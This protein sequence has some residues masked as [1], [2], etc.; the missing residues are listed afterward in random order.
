[1]VVFTKIA[2][3]KGVTSIVA[4]D[5]NQVVIGGGDGSLALFYVE[6]PDCQELMRVNL[7]GAVFSISPSL[8]SVQML[9]STNK[10]FIYRIRCADLS[11]ILLNENHTDNIISFYSSNDSTCRIGSCSLDGTIRLWSLTDFNV[12]SRFFLSHTL[13]PWSLHF[14]DEVM[15]SGWNDG[16]IRCFRTDNCEPLW[17]IDNAHK[18][19]VTTLCFSHNR[20]FLC[21]GGTEG[22]VRV[23]ETRSKDMVSHL[24]EHIQKVTKVGLFKDDLH[25]LTTA[26][27]KSILIWDLNK[28]KRISSYQQSMGGVNNFQLS[29]IDENFLVTI[30]QDR[31]ITFWDLRHAKPV[32]IMGSNP[33][34]QPDQA[35]EL[36]AL[37]ISNDGKY[38]ATGGTAGIIRVWDFN[39]YHCLFEQ[40]A[41]SKTCNSLSYTYDDKFLI[42]A[43]ADSQI[44]AF[45]ASYL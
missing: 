23:W 14:T 10:G 44:L 19:G 21:S 17:T 11:K 34:N 1:M 43:G 4:L 29:P 3:A 22:E 28:E 36:F 16:K 42:S 38:V 15:I 12:Y 9:A 35:D 31:K 20:K 45:R 8:D 39:N 41:H 40:Y 6:E 37:S 18:G 33:N 2:C 5:N 27:D 13:I 7:F 24:K 26:K 32:K 30:G 25:L